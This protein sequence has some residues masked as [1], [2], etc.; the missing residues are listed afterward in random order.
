MSK[1][2]KRNTGTRAA[3][4]ARFSPGPNQ[5]EESITGQFREGEYLCEKN[6]WNI[7]FRYA[8]RSLTGRTD[9][10]PQ[11]QQMIKD[12]ENGLFDIL[13]CYKTERFARNRLDAAIYKN[14]LRKCGVRVVYSK[15]TIPEGPEGIILE[16]VLE[17]LDEYYSKDLS[18]KITRGF[19]DN[20]LQGKTLGG[21]APYGYRVDENG[22]YIIYEDEAVVL[23]EVF[24]RYASGEK[25]I[26]IAEDLNSRGLRT[27][28]GNLFNKNSFNN[29]FH[30]KKYIGV[31]S[32]ESKDENFDDV[33]NEEGIP[34]IVDKVLFEKAHSRLAKNKRETQSIDTPS[35]IFYLSGKM[36]DEACGGAYVGDSGTSKS[37]TRH[38]YYTCQ[39]KKQRKGCKTKSLR[40]D[41][42]EDL[43][44]EQT[45]DFVLN[46]AV[47]ENLAEWISELE[48]D[49]KDNCML[50][51]IK[52]ELNSTRTSIQNIMKA[53]EQGIF[54]ETTKSRLL[55]LEE[56][57]AQ[58]ESQY[59]VEDIKINAPQVEK[60]FIKFRFL[61]IADY[62]VSD[63][64]TK[65]LVFDKFINTVVVQKESVI[66]AYNYA[67][68]ENCYDTVEL[69][70]QALKN[71]F[72]KSVRMSSK[73]WR[74]GDSNS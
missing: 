50:K 16:S 51:S 12:A 38:Y 10:R 66:I 59:Q 25:A 13:V 35:P 60:D 17:G 8:D 28:T 14:R 21:R 24:L 5:R 43:I 22:K 57:Q 20:A 47:I 6:N 27:S 62:D 26:S 42:I 70:F 63:P 39:N 69:D 55:E 11:F 23:R 37:K 2:K 33:Y 19:Y 71:S 36:F 46:E 34:P 40:K 74:L 61:E 54:T 73:W 32:Y 3:L 72:E 29:W 64:N 18:Q 49:Q 56:R 45:K 52:S 67:P 31:Y 44:L 30:N 53:I 41:F 7:L 58:L 15:M 48:K 1:S 65:E 9:D 4:Y 68:T